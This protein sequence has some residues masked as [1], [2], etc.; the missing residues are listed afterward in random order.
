MLYWNPYLGPKLSFD[1]LAEVIC[2]VLWFGD[3]RDRLV[4]FYRVL[5]MIRDGP[6]QLWEGISEFSESVELL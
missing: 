2:V 3:V 6:I 5:H 1:W 4:S